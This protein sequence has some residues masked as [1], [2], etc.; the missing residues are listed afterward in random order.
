MKEKLD[1]Q[2]IID[3]P[4]SE[5]IERFFDLEYPAPEDQEDIEGHKAKA[6]HLAWN[7]CGRVMISTGTKDY[8][9]IMIT[10]A[11]SDGSLVFH[12]FLA[13]CDWKKFREGKHLFGWYLLTTSRAVQRTSA[14]AVALFCNEA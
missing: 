13:G 10:E 14:R 12:V 4:L 5:G 1:F 7:W 2:R 6:L 3:A 11:R 9:R 8:T